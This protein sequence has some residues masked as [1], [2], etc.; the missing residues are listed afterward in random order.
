[1]SFAI[2]VLRV[3]FFSLKKLISMLLGHAIET[4]CCRSRR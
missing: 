4:L 2:Y 3:P 1:M